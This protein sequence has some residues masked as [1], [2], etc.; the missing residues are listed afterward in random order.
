MAKRIPLMLC[1]S[2][3]EF[4]SYHYFS[5]NGPKSHR[6]EI[7]ESCNP[8]LNQCGYAY[9][10]DV[11]LPVAEFYDF[12]HEVRERLGT[13]FGAVAL[14]WGHVLDGDLHLNIF[15]PGVFQK[16]NEIQELLEPYVFIRVLER[17]GSISAEHGLGRMKSKFLPMAKSSEEVATM[18]ALKRIFD[19]HGILNPGK[20]LP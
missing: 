11:A 20:F 6:W 2:F 18:R 8:I 4:K 15:V 14:A 10:Y 16:M 7:R 9:K 1:L 3:C 13:R 17:K 19:P 5:G 12:V